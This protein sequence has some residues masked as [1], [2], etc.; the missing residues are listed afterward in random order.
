MSGLI[1]DTLLAAVME[2]V[3]FG[4]FVMLNNGRADCRARHVRGAHRNLF[5]I[6][7]QQDG[8]QLDGLAGLARQEVHLDG[9]SLDGFILLAATLYNC[10][11]LTHSSI[12]TSPRYPRH[13]ARRREGKLGIQTDAPTLAGALAKG[14]IRRIR[15]SVKQDFEGC[16]G[17]RM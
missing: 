6:N 16:Q 7:Q 1:A 9:G 8:I 5:T 10:V 2:H 13:T 14:I 3:N 4:A 11:L 17:K 12:F 15:Q